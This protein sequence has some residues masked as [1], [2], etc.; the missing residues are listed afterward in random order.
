MVLGSSLGTLSKP[1]DPLSSG[2]KS[3]ISKEYNGN[4]AKIDLLILPCE[5]FD[6]SV[7][8]SVIVTGAK[9]DA[10]HHLL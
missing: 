10:D 9:V 2:R 8:D 5:A 4:R 1:L 3:S 7:T 6:I